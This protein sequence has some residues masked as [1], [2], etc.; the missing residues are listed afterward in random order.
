[1]STSTTDKHSVKDAL[2]YVADAIEGFRRLG[3]H[4]AEA[5]AW[6]VLTTFSISMEESA[7]SLAESL[8]RIKE[9]C[10]KIGIV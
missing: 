6:N 2:L 5:K 1:M 10:S 4:H 7:N 9:A 3:D 8:D